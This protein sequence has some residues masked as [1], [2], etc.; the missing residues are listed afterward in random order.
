MVICCTLQFRFYFGN[1]DIIQVTF[2]NLLML[3][4]MAWLRSFRI[5]AASSQVHMR[6]FFCISRLFK[7][8]EA[9][10]ILQKCAPLC[11]ARHF[12]PDKL[13]YSRSVRPEIK[14]LNESELVSAAGHV[15]TFVR[16]SGFWLPP[17][18]ASLMGVSVAVHQMVTFF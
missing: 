3:R 14:P 18:L 1:T 6:V 7:T 16:T 11:P 4:L 13:D 5:H 8:A 10:W 9:L 15:I 2:L 17:P 12:L